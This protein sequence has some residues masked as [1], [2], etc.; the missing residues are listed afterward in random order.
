MLIRLRR[1][2]DLPS[3]RWGLR[4]RRRQYELEITDETAGVRHWGPTSSAS[5]RLVRLG[6]VHTTDAHDWLTR[7]DE[8]HA[9]GSD[10]WVTDPWRRP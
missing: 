2:D 6:G 8:L 1:L 4:R 10:A 3:G 7:A 9:E 5:S